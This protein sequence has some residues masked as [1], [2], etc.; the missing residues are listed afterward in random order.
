M[1]LI[2]QEFYES[3]I[4]GH[5]GVEHTFRRLNAN[6]SWEGMRQEVKTFVS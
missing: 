2:L 5:A 6:F 4:G 3:Y 1:A